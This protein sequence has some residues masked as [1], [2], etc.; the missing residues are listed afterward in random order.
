MRRDGRDESRQ[1]GQSF[2]E[3]ATDHLLRYAF[4]MG[5]VKG[6]VLDAACGCG[7]GSYMLQTL[8]GEVVGVDADADALG[9]AEKHFPGPKYIQGRI[10]E[11]PW[12]GQFETVVSF[13]TIEHI[14]E[15]EAA[16]QA[17]RRACI[18]T[19]I[20]SVPNE[21]KYPFKAEIFAKDTSPHYRHYTPAQF[22]SLLEGAGFKVVT[23]A[24]QINK[25]ECLMIGG[26]NGKF[27]TYVCN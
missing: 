5:H 13:E 6:R 10:E 8:G 20:A 23:K 16:L 12:E 18:G 15:P 7:Y 25:Q 27:I 19:F 24:C 2:Y 4:A 9:W 14:K 11:A 1:W 22:E 17:F 21:E 26:T 3:I